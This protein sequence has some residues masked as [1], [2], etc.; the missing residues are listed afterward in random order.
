MPTVNDKVLDEITGHSVDL[1]RV[2]AGLRKDV[3]R[4]LK[5]L[6]KKLV[7]MLREARLSGYKRE[8]A[9]IRRMEVLLAQTRKTISGSYRGIDKVDDAELT[10]L[11][12]V[13]EHQAVQSINKS[14]K[15]SVLSVGMSM[16]MLESI[17]KDTL[18][19]GAPTKEWWSRQSSQL[20]N[21]FKDLVRTGVML[22]ESTEDMV[23]KFSGTRESRYLDGV[24]SKAY[25]RAEG[26]IRTSIQVIANEAR[27]Q[28]YTNNDDIVKG[29]EWV[30]T[31]DGRTSSICRALDGAVWDNNKKPI[32]HSRPF[33]GTTAHWNCRSTQV[34]VLKS[35]KELG[36]KKKFKE[37]P[38]ST[39]ASMD[40]QVSEKIN[41]E[42]WLKTKSE[43]FQKDVLGEGKWALWKK[44]KI[45]FT[46]LVDQ[47]GNEVSLEHIKG[48]LN[49]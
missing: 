17:G 14:I 44:G 13:A 33:P 25:R 30:S 21:E 23:R 43:D 28:T 34:A 19:E 46:D 9:K 32:G 8:H 24:V 11:A 1:L 38:E 15:A 29:I 47:T 35:W 40:G 3:V 37:I 12:G 7:I 48:K 41:Y 4:E 2:E 6:S 16:E 31:L 18:I 42:E 22:N 20:Q 5:K 39:R 27:L 45:G 36:A 10:S 26:L 49:T